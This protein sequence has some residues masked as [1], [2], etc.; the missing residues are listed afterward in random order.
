MRRRLVL[1]S[2]SV[3]STV[4]LAFL[5][6]LAVLVKDL[7]TNR[8]LTAA[9]RDAESVARLIATLSPS[10]GVQG[11][12]SALGGVSTLSSFS[13]SLILPDGTVVGTPVTPAEYAGDL[14]RA[15]AG[16]AFR[17]SVPGGEAS[18]VPV[19]QPD[20]STVVVRVFVST[21]EL[22]EGVVRS[23]LILAALGF[24]LVT[25][26]VVMADRLARTV[27]EPVRQLSATAARLGEGDL[28]ARVF[29]SGPEEIRDVGAE[30]NR[31]AHQ[32]TLLL[33]QERETA[34]DL[35]HRLRTPLTAVQLD[36]DGLPEGARK[37]RLL[38][39]LADLERTVDF[40]IRE[41]RRPVGSAFDGPSDLAA[42]VR[43][44]A[45]FW[46]AL[47]E[48]QH[49]PF[50]V[51]VDD[52]RAMVRV[53]PSDAEAMIDALLGNV[54]AHTPEGTAIRVALDVDAGIAVLGVD[55]AGPGFPD[56]GVIER[57][58]SGGTSTGLGLDIVRRRAEGAGG[59]TTLERSEQLGGARVVVSLPLVPVGRASPP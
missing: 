39:D 1:L 18:Y 8:A 28:G 40:I 34:A 24:I 42:A 48:E 11:A 59:S 9:Q 55:D 36:A 45:D 30:F 27:V 20:L 17:V 5:I 6:P 26:A 49:R 38:E 51:A 53:A 46:S 15:R 4:V 13:I 29:P 2:L 3:T 41:A 58:R 33:Q 21:A 43:D 37:D 47:A 12:I 57:G 50:E 32:V 31:L 35:S 22:T 16:T 10:E 19:L 56:A 52:A 44:R 14:D 23:W 25:L 7:A 54:F